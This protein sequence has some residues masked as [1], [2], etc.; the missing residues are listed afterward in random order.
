MS[1]ESNDS[2]GLSLMRANDR[3]DPAGGAQDVAGMDSCWNKQ[4]DHLLD[5]V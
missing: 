5:R 1:L 2:A 4:P 3:L